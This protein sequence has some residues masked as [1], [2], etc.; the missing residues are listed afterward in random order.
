ML[1]AATIN[2]IV[3]AIA[4]GTWGTMSDRFGRRLALLVPAVGNLAQC[5]LIAG[6]AYFRWSFWTVIVAGS[7]AGIAGGSGTMFCGLFAFTADVTSSRRR[8]LYF[9]VLAAVQDVG[10]MIGN[11]AV[12]RVVTWWGVAAPFYVIAVIY[13]LLA[14]YAIAL[15]ESLTEE[16]RVAKLDWRRVNVVGA[17]SVLWRSEKPGF[18][19]SLGLLTATFTLTY[20]A[21]IAWV[22]IVV[23]YA[24]Q[25]FHWDSN[26]ISYFGAAE[27]GGRS[28]AVLFLAPLL[29]RARHMVAPGAVVT[30]ALLFQTGAFVFYAT[31]TETATMFSGVAFES[32]SA[33]AMPTMRAIYSRAMPDDEQGKVLSVISAVETIINVL[34][35][36]IVPAVFASTNHKCPR[37]TIYGVLGLSVLSVMLALVYAKWPL[38]IDAVDVDDDEAL[39]RD[40][41]GAGEVAIAKQKAAQVGETDTLI[42]GASCPYI[43]M[44]KGQDFKSMGSGKSTYGSINP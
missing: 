8:T 6:F 14:A 26:M 12:G 28:L 13:A 24:K 7:F 34:V 22:I 30:T 35:P 40:E 36:I 1:Y 9:S 29:F 2:S 44:H 5:L 42:D 25:L 31:A 41:D 32:L 43:A 39:L 19:R 16:K 33:V 10:I 18:R 20:A 4:A 21:F 27:S 37:C 38:P 17:L 11:L 15:P 23:L 3:P